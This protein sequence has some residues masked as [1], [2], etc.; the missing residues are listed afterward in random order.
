MAL[1]RYEDCVERHPIADEDFEQVTCPT[2]RAELGLSAVAPQWRYVCAYDTNRAW[3]GPEEGGWWFDTGIMLASI[4]CETDEQ[5]EEAKARLLKRYG[6]EFEGNHEIGSVLC[7]GVLG[8]YVQD[9]PGA[10]YPT[11]RPHYE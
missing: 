6:P 9:E 11:Q 8:I 5:V 2:C 1:C 4:P 3:G 10:D 7:E